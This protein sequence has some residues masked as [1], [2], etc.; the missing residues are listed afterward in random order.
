M[1]ISEFVDQ[2]VR[3]WVEVACT[4][5]AYVKDGFPGGEDNVRASMQGFLTYHSIAK[6][7]PP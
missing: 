2:V 7:S 3:E 4:I 1:G 5:V 6:F